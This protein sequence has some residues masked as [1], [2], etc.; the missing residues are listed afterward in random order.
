MYRLIKMKVNAIHAL[1]I[2]ILV[3]FTN[4][5]EQRGNNRKR[6]VY[7]TQVSGE[8]NIMLSVFAF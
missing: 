2:D 3:Y 4:G 1:H 7:E 6:E 5:S 8:K